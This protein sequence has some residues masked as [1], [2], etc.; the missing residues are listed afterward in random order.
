M[1]DPTSNI[2]LNRPDEGQSDWHLPLNENFGI[3]DEEVAALLDK[4][5]SLEQRV[6]DLES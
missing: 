1:P 5:D 6:E 2:G 3:M 4:I